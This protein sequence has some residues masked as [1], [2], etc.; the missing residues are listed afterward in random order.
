MAAQ[1]GVKNA[2][3]MSSRIS[4]RIRR[5]RNQC[6]RAMV[7]STTQRR[8]PSPE[9][10]AMP[11]RAMTG[12]IPRVRSSAIGW[13]HDLTAP[14][15]REY[16]SV[17]VVLDHRSDAVDVRRKHMGADAHHDDGSRRRP[18]HSSP[19]YLARRVAPRDYD[20]PRPDGERSA[21]V[22]QRGTGVVRP[23]ASRSGLPP[24]PIPA[25]IARM[26]RH[27]RKPCFE[28]QLPQHADAYTRV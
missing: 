13:L 5:R 2:S 9:P 18:A 22:L 23:A 12:V 3:W 25:S 17:P 15:R 6:S 26:L 10:C 20:G 16:R 4:Q 11:R 1:A 24:G 21:R 8:V 28:H 7:C 19:S 14:H 27:Q